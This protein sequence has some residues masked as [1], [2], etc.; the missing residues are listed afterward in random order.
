MNE[1]T[2]GIKVIKMY[3]WEKPFEKIV[4]ALRGEEIK[5][6]THTAYIQSLSVA[7]QLFTERVTLYIIIVF[8][9]LLGHELTGAVVFSVSQVI[10]SLLLNVCILFPLGLTA[11]AEVKTTIFRLEEFLL[12]EERE[13]IPKIVESVTKETG[14]VNLVD[15]NASWTTQTILPTLSNMSFK[16]PPGSLCCVIGSIGAG[17]SSILHLILRELPLTS[18]I[19]R[20]DGKISYSSQEPWVFAS[21]IRSNIL[22]GQPFEQEKYHSVVSACALERDFELFP[23]GDKTHVGDKG[24]SLSG[25]QKA[26]INLARAVYRDADIYL[27]DDPL[28][29]VDPHVAKHL[30]NKCINE[31]LRNKTRILVTHQTQFLE[32]ADFVLILDNGKVKNFIK[33]SELSDTDLIRRL[34]IPIETP[35]TSKAP[36]EMSDNNVPRMS[37]DSEMEDEIDESQEK[38]ELIEKGSIGLNIYK[39]YFQS[40]TTLTVLSIEIFLLII[41]QVFCNCC[42]LWVTFWTNNIALSR[43]NA[44][45]TSPLNSGFDSTEYPGDTTTMTSFMNST[46]DTKGSSLTTAPGNSS[47]NMFSILDRAHLTQNFY[48]KVHTFLIVFA[49]SLTILRSGVFFRICM[50]A[51]K[52]LHNLMFSNILHAKMRFFD[53][54][55]SG[56]ILNRFSNDM[57]IIDEKLPIST[58]MTLQTVGIASGIMVMVFIKSVYMIIPAIILGVIIGWLRGFFLTTAQ[59][60]KRLESIAK[61]PVFSYVTTSLNGL[62]TIRASNAED[63]VKR[64]FDDIQDGHTAAF[65]M[66]LHTFQAFGFYLDMTSVIFLAIIIVQFLLSPNALSGDVGLVLSQCLIVVVMIQLATR[67]LAEVA[68]NMTSVER[69]LQYT[70]LDNEGPFESLPVNKP[71]LTWPEAG[72]I[73]FKNVY[74]QYVI[75]EEPVLK[76]L[77]FEIKPGEKIGIVGRTGAGKSSLISA[78]FR[79]ARIDGVIEIDGI[80]VGKVGLTELRSKISIIPQEPTL[81][82]ESI[83][84]NLDP[85]RR[86]HDEIL[87]K[88]LESVELKKVIESLDMVVTEGGSNFS[89]G[90]RQLICLARAIVRNNKILVMDEAT[91]NV[92]PYTDDLIQQSIRKNFKSCTVLT[93]AHR[94]NTII[95]NDKVIVMDAGQILEFAPP[96]ELLQDSESF[97]VLW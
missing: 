41:A 69:L 51:S 75:D 20:V 63:M 26:R 55:P 1:I 94:I 28:S 72:R 36:Q 84:Y 85:F 15:V 49:I 71:S 70:K 16:L 47:F 27:L 35:I 97:S 45:I 24:S 19:L 62:Q 6:I 82:S 11:A 67:N 25:G 52:K 23:F 90:Q 65:Y 29:A 66:F 56:R 92:D 22:F 18:G 76:N 58:L 50:S 12:K 14:L 68:N 96:Y 33:S 44:N 48:I 54:N 80:D 61:A 64:E 95:D 34:S 93:V 17:K 79:L 83:G 3:A 32:H 42:D 10:T 13:E 9:V 77:N 21:N 38:Q 43:S 8:Y 57:G 31:Y 73:S 89:V 4:S 40:G 91:A 59:N 74:V 86:Y 60:I 88:A 78:L 5:S 30:M 7:I 2:T 81:F 39:K 87:W 46:M 37:V 53:T